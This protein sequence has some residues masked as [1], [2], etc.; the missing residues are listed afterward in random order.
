[1]ARTNRKQT[2]R[3]C[4]FWENDKRHMHVDEGYCHRYPPPN[5]WSDHPV[6]LG[7]IASPPQTF[8]TNWCGEWSKK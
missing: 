6:H 3:N 7:W 5:V 4:Q 1:M 2:C 8:P